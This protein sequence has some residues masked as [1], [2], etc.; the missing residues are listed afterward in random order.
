[1]I[2]RNSTLDSRR[3]GKVKPVLVCD[4]KWTT[5]TDS[6]ENH[7]RRELQLSR[8]GCREAPRRP[9][10]TPVILEDV[11]QQYVGMVGLYFT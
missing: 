5:R 4:Q 9:R 8:L 10:E 1:M 11:G 7:G 6:R 2:N 3:L